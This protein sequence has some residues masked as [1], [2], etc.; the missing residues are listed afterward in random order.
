[1]GRLWQNLRYTIRVLAKN[2]GFTTVA[3]LSLALGIGANTAIFTLI[4]ALLLRDLPVRQPERLIQ[5]VAVRPDAKVPF[6]YPMFREVGRGQRV[7]T[8]LIGWG[9]GGMQN[10]EVNGVLS[11]NYVAAVTGNGYSELGVTPLLGRLLI[12][13]DSNPS[14]GTTSQVTVLGYEFWRNR[15]GGA[16][17]VVGKQ[18]RIEG[19]PFTIIGVT[20]RSFTGMT[21]GE[22]PDITI[23]ITAY[24]ALM[25]GNE[26]TLDSRSI[27]W[28][29][30]IGRLKDG[31]TIEQARAQLQ[32]FWLDVLLATASTETPGARRERFLSMGLE[33]TSAAKGFRSD[34]R[35]QFTRPLYVLAGIVGL[36]LLV[37]C[38]NLANLMLARAAAR[39]HEMSVRV[40]IGASRWS[41]ARQ[42]L[43]ECLALSVAGALLGLVFAFSGSRLLVLLMTQGSLFPVALDVSPDLRV[44]SLTMFVAVLTA[45]SFG[46]A[47]AWRCS[48]EDPASVLQQNARS[49]G[50]GTG[51]LSKALIVT[52]VALSLVLL[53]GAGLLE[54]SFEKLYSIDL[55]F[56]KESV[57]EI[58]L[59]PKPGG[60]QNLNLNSYH[61]QLVA[62]I[63]SLPG[64]SSVSFGDA[65]I[66]NPQGWHDT[67]S[68]MTADSS[69][70]IRLMANAALVS[71]GFFRTLGI[72][73][74]R[75][76]DFNETDDEKHARIAIVN[77]NL[78]ER[79]F[80]NIDAI[81]KTIRFGFM[82]DY[83]NIE[84]VGIARN[85]RIFDIRD[86]TTP[87][88][89]LSSFQ[90]PHEWGGLIVR[91]KEAPETL[92]K[93]VGHEVESLGHE[94][95]R[96]TRTVAQ[97]ISTELVEER[98]TAILSGFFAALAILLAS[99]GLY[100]L[101]SYAVTRRT[102]EIGIRVAVGAQRE[103]VLW[104]VLR[105]TLT[106]ALLGIAIG[107]PS[108]LAATRL[109]ASMLFG[110]TS[111]DVPTIVAVSALLLVV[112]L[113]AGYLPARRASAIDPI[114][115]LRTE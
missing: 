104:L 21:V 34:L 76:R 86:A 56:Q 89:F 5:L 67:V 35:T 46:I 92:A 81:G 38:V 68:Q 95:V 93:T 39:S 82:P 108:A 27:L 85:A 94:Y 33:V 52:Q 1:M 91:T 64:V 99:I 40:A 111:S 45:I 53:L 71:P 11:Q 47:P 41:V 51:K 107:I 20:R 25:E 30:V 48:R 4:N 62:R 18:I 80:P 83:E 50:G 110:L 58:A 6:S 61:K 60:Y 26:F 84:I 98:V 101:M 32:S 42:V 49:V 63:S 72:P 100:G 24:P 69:T 15:F 55:G 106:L 17:D 79:L 65:T 97:T 8:G 66:P 73:L 113:F 96:R 13:E 43:A 59:Y 44:L 57:L 14:S 70:G 109:I 112:A 74:L 2:P 54:R 88:I 16:P 87:V 90:Y 10:V 114:V 77:S 75:G 102:R 7:F 103:G 19:H 28:L 9:T 29:S 12:P 22:P 37:A 23:P 31:I 115:A 105:E 36:I 3:I 78:A